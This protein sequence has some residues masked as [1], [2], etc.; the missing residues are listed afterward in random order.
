MSMEGLDSLRV[1]VGRDPDL[2]GRLR[3]LAPDRFVEEVSRIAADFGSDVTAAEIEA[4]IA[5]ARQDWMLRWI[6]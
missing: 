5:Q 3:A 1:L 6:R 2:A 4:A